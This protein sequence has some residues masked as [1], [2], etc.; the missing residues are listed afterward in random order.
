MCTVSLRAI[1]R[2]KTATTTNPL[3]PTVEPAKATSVTKV[4]AS[5]VSFSEKPEN[6]GADVHRENVGDIKQCNA[7]N[8][9][10]VGDHD[11][12]NAN[13]YTYEP[14]YKQSNLHYFQSRLSFEGKGIQ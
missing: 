1:E 12:F 5:S 14:C 10:D 7:N 11:E 3:F 8:N 2:A 6:I 4:C 9:N 13:F